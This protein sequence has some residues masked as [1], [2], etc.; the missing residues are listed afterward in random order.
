MIKDSTIRDEEWANY[1]RRLGEVLNE[2][3][4]TKSQRDDI[5]E[6]IYDLERVFNQA[7]NS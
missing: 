5:E 7:N 4:L 3:A 2:I 6:L 1:T